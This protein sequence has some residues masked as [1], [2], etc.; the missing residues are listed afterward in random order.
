[1]DESDKLDKFLT[2]SDVKQMYEDLSDIED[3]V[4]VNKRDAHETEL[5]T[6]CAVCAEVSTR[7]KCLN[8]ASCPI[9]RTTLQLSTLGKTYC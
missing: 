7:P 6:K 5:L 2:I 8:S 4:K 3:N 1:M 9:L